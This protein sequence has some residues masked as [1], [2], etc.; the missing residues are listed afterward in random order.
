MA[1]APHFPYRRVHDRLFGVIGIFRHQLFNLL[2]IA[3]RQFQQRLLGLLTRAAALTADE[4]A[5]RVRAGTRWADDRGP[6][7]LCSDPDR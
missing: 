6:S 4:P 3:F 5:A 2:V 7:G 1:V